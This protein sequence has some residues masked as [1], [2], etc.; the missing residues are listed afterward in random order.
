MAPGWPGSVMC[1]QRFPECYFRS[2]PNYENGRSLT[3]EGLG[4][5]TQQSLGN[6]GLL[7]ASALAD[8]E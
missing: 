3:E 2:V 8:E 6:R 7:T 5:R 1:P 4:L